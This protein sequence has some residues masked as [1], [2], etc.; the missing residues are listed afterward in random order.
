MGG[1]ATA[2]SRQDRVF[3][4]ETE[5]AAYGL[6]RCT[7]PTRGR[8]TAAMQTVTARLDNAANTLYRNHLNYLKDV[9]PEMGRQFRLVYAIKF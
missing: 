5:T 6:L 8:S 4:S 9:V 2:V 1:N 7:P 3:G